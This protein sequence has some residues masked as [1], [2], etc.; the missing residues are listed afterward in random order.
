[1]SI[2]QIEPVFWKVVKKKKK[3]SFVSR[4]KKNANGLN[5]KYP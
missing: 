3:V 2:S 1:M 5:A 4:E